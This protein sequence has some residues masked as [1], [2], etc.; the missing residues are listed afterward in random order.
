MKI[1]VPTGYNDKKL[2]DW[3]NEMTPYIKQ[4][5]AVAPYMKFELEA[6]FHNIDGSEGSQTCYDCEGS[7]E[8]YIEET[9]EYDDCS[10]CNGYGTLDA[11]EELKTRIESNLPDSVLDNITFMKAYYDS[12]VNCELTFTIKTTAL[13][14]VVDVIKAFTD[15]ADGYDT[16]N[17]GFHIAVLTDKNGKYPC[18]TLLD[19]NK[20]E[21][22]KYNVTKILP[23]ILYASANHG[24][25]RSLYYRQLQISEQKYS[26]IHIIRGGFEYRVFEPCLD[27]PEKV[28]DYIKV[29]ANTLKYYSKR[30]ISDK[31]AYTLELPGRLADTDY[32]KTSIKSIFQDINN[33][34]ILRKTMPYVDKDLPIK[35]TLSDK[36]LA[37]IQHKQYIKAVAKYQAHLQDIQDSIRA[38]IKRD[39]L[40]YLE[41]QRQ[42]DRLRDLTKITAQEYVDI[43]N[44]K[45]YKP[46]SLLT[47]DTVDKKDLYNRVAEYH[48]NRVREYHIDEFM[49]STSKIEFKIEGRV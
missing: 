14:Q 37:K 28:F 38:R 34:T 6:N 48:R 3:L 41:Y 13:A 23:A 2:T 5:S 25:T 31:L 32:T 21:N 29:I 15:C 19:E 22:F 39:Y 11:F 35:I 7:G 49:R 46:E 17:A 4:I 43:Q 33:L 44:N 16:N 8:E 26:A 10:T 47:T 1:E 40:D 30:K 24:T 27:N 20:L 36:Q 42:S 12:S 45:K 18:D 9:N